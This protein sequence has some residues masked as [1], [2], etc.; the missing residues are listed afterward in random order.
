MK[1]KLCTRLE[2]LARPRT[3]IKANLEELGYGR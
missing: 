1:A 3:A 2:E